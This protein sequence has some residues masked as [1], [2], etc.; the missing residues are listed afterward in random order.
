MNEKQNFSST[1]IEMEIEVVD[2]IYDIYFIDGG[3]IPKPVIIDAIFRMF[4]YM[5]FL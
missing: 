4:S 3:S 5:F 2:R 1:E